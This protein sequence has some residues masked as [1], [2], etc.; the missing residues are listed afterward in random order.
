MLH[1][2]IR[3]VLKIEATPGIISVGKT[4][5]IPPSVFSHTN[6]INYLERLQHLKSNRFNWIYSDCT[7]VVIS[8]HW[9]TSLFELAW[10]YNLEIDK[11]DYER[12]KKNF[13]LLTNC[14]KNNRLLEV[15]N[16]EKRP[17]IRTYSLHKKGFCLER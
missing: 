12:F 1:W 2:F 9:G 6:S 5:Q 10:G 15:R 4:G 3:R 8:Y 14:L 7:T 13:W 16:D 17:I 11:D